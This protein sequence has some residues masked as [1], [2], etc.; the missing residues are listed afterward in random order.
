MS[1]TFVV[2]QIFLQTEVF[3]LLDHC[4]RSPLFV[5]VGVLMVYLVYKDDLCHAKAE[6]FRLSWIFTV[7]RL[8][9]CQLYMPPCGIAIVH[10]DG[11]GAPAKMR[12]WLELDIVV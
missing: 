4:C 8:G 7:V 12:D 3:S 2:V 10:H 6:T 1:Q 5:W 9:W 11:W